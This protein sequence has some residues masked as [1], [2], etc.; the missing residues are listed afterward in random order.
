MEIRPGLATGAHPTYQS[1][2]MNRT[3]VSSAFRAPAAH[4]RP[5][6][7]DD[8]GDGEG[9]MHEHEVPFEEL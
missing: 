5:E 6:T 2:H 9:M 1:V 7:P 8:N 3:R 4:G